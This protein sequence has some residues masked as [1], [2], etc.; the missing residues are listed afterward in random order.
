VLRRGI[1]L[2]LSTG[3]RYFVRVKKMAAMFDW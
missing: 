3:G 1:G 2:G